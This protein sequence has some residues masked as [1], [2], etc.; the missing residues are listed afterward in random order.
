MACARNPLQV[1]KE[2]RQI[3]S[4][5]DLTIIEKAGRFHV[6]RNTQT[7]PAWQGQCGQPQALRALVCKLTNFE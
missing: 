5:Y 4:D 6:Y 1:L 2:A 7:G 3:A